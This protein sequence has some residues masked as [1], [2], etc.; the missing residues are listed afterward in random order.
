VVLIRF[1]HTRAPDLRSKCLEQLRRMYGRLHLLQDS[2][3]SP[4]GADEVG[5]P[6]GPHVYF[7]V[8]AFLDPN[9]IGLDDFVIRVAQQREGKTV[10]FDEFLVTFN[11]IAADAEKLDFSLEFTPGIAQV[12]GFGPCTPGYRSFG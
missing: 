9:L 2:F 8:D 7:P 6:V 11:A 5:G 12:T 3:N 4:V 10:F 1:G